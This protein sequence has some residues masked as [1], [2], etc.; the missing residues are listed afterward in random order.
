MLF[1]YL[2]TIQE[3]KDL[4][5][6]KNQSIDKLH[7]IENK[8]EIKR[9]LYQKLTSEDEVVKKAKD[10]FDLIRIDHLSKVAVNKNRIKNIQALVNK[11]YD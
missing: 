8:L 9:V 4:N 1:I 2:F 7:S 3:I 5:K 10:K 11:K 6:H